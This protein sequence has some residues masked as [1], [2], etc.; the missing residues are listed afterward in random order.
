MIGC[1]R[2]KLTFS[3]LW[4]STGQS[5]PIYDNPTIFHH[6]WGVGNRISMERHLCSSS[7]SIEEVPLHMTVRIRTRSEEEDG[8]THLVDSK[9]WIHVITTRKLTV[10]NLATVVHTE[11]NR[12]DPRFS[13]HMPKIGCPLAI[14]IHPPDNL[15][16]LA[17]ASIWFSFHD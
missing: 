4:S 1:L 16:L 8:L 6:N 11:E 3:L 10:V 5:A 2:L 17:L 15:M 12:R 14:S 13:M 9:R 7:D